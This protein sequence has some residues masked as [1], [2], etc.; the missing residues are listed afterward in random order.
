MIKRTPE[1]KVKT[2]RKPSQ[3]TAKKPVTVTGYHWRKNGAG[4]DLR[5]DVYVTSN[6]LRKRKQPYVAHMSQEAFREL[7]KANK[8]AA[9]E[10]AVA[11]WIESHSR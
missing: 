1:R 7:K 3:K 5:K 10:R 11:E 8:G 2:A 4:W 9:L 6:G